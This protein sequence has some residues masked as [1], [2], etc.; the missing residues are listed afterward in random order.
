MDDNKDNN[1][2]TQQQQHVGLMSLISRVLASKYIRSELSRHV[3][4]IHKQLDITN[5]FH[6]SD[7]SSLYQCIQCGDTT[8]FIHHCDQLD[9]TIHSPQMLLETMTESFKLAVHKQNV[10]LVNYIIERFRNGSGTSSIQFIKHVKDSLMSNIEYSHIPAIR[11][12]RPMIHTLMAYIPE[13]APSNLVTLLLR[14]ALR[15]HQDFDLCIEISSMVHPHNRPPIEQYIFVGHQ[16]ATASALFLSNQSRIIDDFERYLVSHQQPLGGYLIKPT[17]LI[18]FTLNHR[19]FDLLLVIASHI[20]GTS[21]PSNPMGLTPSTHPMS[22]DTLAALVRVDRLIFNRLAMFGDITFMKHSQDHLRSY[23]DVHG[24]LLHLF[25][26]T[27]LQCALSGGHYDCALYILD[28]ITQ[29]LPRRSIDDR[30]KWIVTGINM[31]QEGDTVPDHV[32]WLGLI[33]RLINDRSV[34]HDFKNLFTDAI[35]A[36]RMDVIDRLEGLI[37]SNP[38]NVIDIDQAL[39]A[40]LQIQYI[41]GI[42]A[43]IVNH[44]GRVFKGIKM[45]YI[46]QCSYDI[47]EM[48]LAKVPPGN[49]TFDTNKVTNME[50][51]TIRMFIKHRHHRDPQC[52]KA[53]LRCAEQLG[54]RELMAS[55]DA[56]SVLQSDPWSP[57]PNAPFSSTNEQEIMLYSLYYAKRRWMVDTMLASPKHLSRPDLWNREPAVNGMLLGSDVLA[58][59]NLMPLQRYERPE[60]IRSLQ[61]REDISRLDKDDIEFVWKR[62]A[63]TLK[64]D[65]HFINKVLTSIA[66]INNIMMYEYVLDYLIEDNHFPVPFIQVPA[67]GQITFNIKQYR[68]YSSTRLIVELF[69]PTNYTQ[70]S[71]STISQYQR[72]LIP[73]KKDEYRIYQSLLTNLGVFDPS[74]SQCYIINQQQHQQQEQ[75]I[76]P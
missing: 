74:N 5:V 69:N 60:S 72:L 76:I 9:I 11:F 25:D 29:F 17:H 70:S 26:N 62:M 10:I 24:P 8:K 6:S 1:N 39:N 48:F 50:A 49:I 68:R 58:F 56:K 71:S 35:R 42:N 2:E 21:Q 46:D 45:E 44:H 66:A 28:N 14:S 7:I 61:Y 54:H 63:D 67:I 55:L 23:I 15:D 40:A 19:L 57:D 51:S 3:S 16:M 22:M 27:M 64:R 75:S 4:L 30:H 47:Q 33:E 13:A 12:S 36:K 43:I 34:D 41:D 59:L 73:L 38:L 37:K 52:L 20:G 31:M 18:N 65:Q 53:L 32:D